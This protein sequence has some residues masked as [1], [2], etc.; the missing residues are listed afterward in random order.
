MKYKI[1]LCLS[2]IMLNSNKWF[3]MELS[4]KTTLGVKKG[5]ILQED[6]EER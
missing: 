4:S 1:R 5:E 2:R 3:T 6:S